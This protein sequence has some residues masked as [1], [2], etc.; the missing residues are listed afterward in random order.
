MQ[1]KLNKFIR[2]AYRMGYYPSLLNVISKQKPNLAYYGYLGD[3]NLGDEMVFWAAKS[4]F[5][6][7]NLIPIKRRMPVFYLVLK[8]LQFGQ[9]FDGVV[10]GGG[11]LI[12]QSFTEAY[13]IQRIAAM[14]K[15]FFVHGTGIRKNWDITEWKDIFGNRFI[16]GLRGPISQ[17]RL[18]S[19]A[20]LETIGDAALHLDD[21]IGKRTN[22]SSN[23]VLFNM[24]THHSYKGEDSAR[25]Q[26]TDL[27]RMLS[28]K[29]YKL[30]FVPF[31]GNDKMI[32]QRLS[33][34]DFEI[35]R[36]PESLHD[37]AIL[38]NNSHFALGERLHFIIASVLFRKPFISVN[39]QDKHD[40]FLQ[41]VCLTD[42][43]FAPEDVCT[44]R[45]FEVFCSETNPYDQSFEEKLC[46]LKDAQLSFASDYKK[47]LGKVI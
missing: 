30:V 32:A 28:D 42:R 31:H 23:I 9:F 44:S 24:G 4:L 8:Y 26:I 41:S 17:E 15:S 1:S 10:I 2:E 46:K 35:A 27:L 29:G 25:K 39:Y 6:E 37:M 21:K 22:N 11:T 33:G 13:F 40:D 34:V 19:L 20:N 43:G 45:M 47:L 5:A 16:G 12:G 3:G 18:N 14:R 7:C 36:K 38:F